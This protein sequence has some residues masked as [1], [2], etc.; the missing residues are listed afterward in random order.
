MVAMSCTLILNILRGFVKVSMAKDI[1]PGDVV[2]ITVLLT[3]IKLITLKI[4]TALFFI[5]LKVT[6]KIQN[7]KTVSPYP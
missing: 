6:V 7:L 3:N 4:I 5:L 1:S 2:N